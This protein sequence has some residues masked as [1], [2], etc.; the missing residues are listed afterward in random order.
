MRGF[1]TSWYSHPTAIIRSQ[2][3]GDTHLFTFIV[4]AIPLLGG[5]TSPPTDLQV[6][7]HLLCLGYPHPAGQQILR[8][9]LLQL[10][11]RYCLSLQRLKLSS[12]GRINFN[13]PIHFFSRS[14]QGIM[15][16][17]IEA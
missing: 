7:H 6:C 13:D 4:A 5:Q 12:V 11:Q 16:R 14:T 15:S 10:I 1:S 2:P 3:E 9:A 17:L 8:Q